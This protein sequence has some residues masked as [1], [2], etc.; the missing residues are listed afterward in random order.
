MHASQ[1]H[2][3]L[4][5]SAQHSSWLR[6]SFPFVFKIQNKIWGKPKPKKKSSHNP[7]NQ[8]Q[9]HIH[10]WE[11]LLSVQGSTSLFTAVGQPPVILP[12]SF[13]IIWQTFPPLLPG[14]CSCHFNALPDT[15]SWLPSYLLTVHFII[16]SFL[17]L[18]ITLSWSFIVVC[19]LNSQ[20]WAN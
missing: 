20:E 12:C 13:N 14:L 1:F 17:L 6:S 7:K 16:S 11:P 9:Q 3:I 5:V 10:S 4:L 19:V 8:A 18:E 2:F 15:G